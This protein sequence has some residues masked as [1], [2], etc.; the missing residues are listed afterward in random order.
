MKNRRLRLISHKILV[1]NKMDEIS[2]SKNKKA[3]LTSKQI[4]TII[5]LIISFAIILSFFLMLGLRSS[6]D[7]ESCRN[8]VVMIGIPFGD[9]VINLKC[10]TQDICFNMGR[11]CDS[12]SKDL[13]TIDVKDKEELVKEMDNLINECWW[14]MGEGKGDYGGKGSCA[15]CHRVYFDDKI[16]EG[17]EFSFKAGIID[18][19]EVYV[20]VTGIIGDNQNSPVF[21]KFSASDLKSIGCTNFV[22]EI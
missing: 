13:V 11:N 9:W 17:K 5:I 8:S 14:M 15:I 3:E 21:V 1:K 19:K 4:I 22:T 2:N 16:K 7:K 12:K 18:P 10:K 6:I 20:V